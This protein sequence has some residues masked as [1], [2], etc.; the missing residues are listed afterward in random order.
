MDDENQDFFDCLYYK[1]IQ[2]AVKV[3]ELLKV[4]KEEEARDIAL[5][6]PDYPAEW[7]YQVESEMRKGRKYR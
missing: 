5:A 1:D 3:C 4:G 2:T 6:Q 7:A